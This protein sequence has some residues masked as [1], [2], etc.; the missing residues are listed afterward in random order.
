MYL[1]LQLLHEEAKMVAL[2]VRLVREEK[3]Q[4]LQRKQYRKMQGAIQK[5]WEEY[6]AGTKSIKQLLKDCAF[7][8]APHIE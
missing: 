3:L 1:L 8:Y 5:N 7:V 4:R 2:Q 6:A